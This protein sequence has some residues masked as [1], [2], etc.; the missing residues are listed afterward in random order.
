MLSCFSC[1]AVIRK[2][3]NKQSRNSE[4]LGTKQE[5]I[6]FPTVLVTTAHGSRLTCTC[7]LVPSYLFYLG[8]ERD[9]QI[10]TKDARGKFM[11]VARDAMQSLASNVNILWACYAMAFFGFTSV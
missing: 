9:V 5:S 8:D 2:H 3:S 1:D 7:R 10:M 11:C 6:S 4:G